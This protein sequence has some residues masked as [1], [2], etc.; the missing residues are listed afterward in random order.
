[1]HLYLLSRFLVLFSSRYQSI[2]RSLNLFN[3]L[4]DQLYRSFNSTVS[5]LFL[6]FAEC[7]QSIS[8]TRKLLPGRW[9]P[10]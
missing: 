2:N 3:R 6:R 1:M 5:K 4:S 10:Q 8:R 9:K 7:R